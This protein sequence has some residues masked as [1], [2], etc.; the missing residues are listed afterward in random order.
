MSEK[1]QVIDKS[2]MV[3]I[4]FEVIGLPKK[5]VFPSRSQIKIKK[6]DVFPLA[7]VFSED[8][9]YDPI[10]LVN[11]AIHYEPGKVLDSMPT[12]DPGVYEMVG[13]FFGKFSLQDQK[14]V[15]SLWELTDIKAY[16]LTEEEV[17][18]LPAPIRSTL[19]TKV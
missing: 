17:E 10:V 7:F 18:S 4:L 3:R 12:S 1:L 13:E 11:T 14:V 15:N 2:A 6:V 16:Q 19:E 8:I 5:G 9:T